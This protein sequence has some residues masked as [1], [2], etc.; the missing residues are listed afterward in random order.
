MV[1]RVS[2]QR[3]L[4]PM[5]V[6]RTLMAAAVVTA[7]ALAA[8]TPTSDPNPDPSAS[9]TPGMPAT[10]VVAPAGTPEIDGYTLVFAK[11]YSESEGPGAEI[12][13]DSAGAIGRNDDDGARGSETDTSDSDGA[14]T[15]SPTT[16]KSPDDDATDSSQPTESSSEKPSD[17]PTPDSAGMHEQ[18]RI[19]GAVLAGDYLL[20]YAN[21]EDGTSHQ[22]TA[23]D[24][25]DGDREWSRVDP[26]W[27]DC[28][29]GELVICTSSEYSGG[30]WTD[31]DAFV[32]DHSTGNL[33]SFDVGASGTFSYVGTSDQ[34][35]YFLTWDGTHAVHM[36]GFDST[37]V[38]VIDKNLRASIPAPTA[39]T[40]IDAWMAGGRAFISIPGSDPGIYVANANAFANY[41][42]ATPCIFA[43]DGM[44]CTDQS[45]ANSL[46]AVDSVGR[47]QWTH[48]LDGAEFLESGEFSGSL[49]QLE[50]QLLP[51]EGSASEPQSTPN[52]SGTAAQNTDPMVAR[53][54]VPAS[55][56]LET[57]DR[58]G[59]T[60]DLGARGTV[61]IG[62][63]EPQAI[64]LSH[65]HSIV[66]VAQ[67]GEPVG[68]ASTP[69]VVSTILM[70]GDG[71]VLS[72]LPDSRMGELSD[73]LLGGTEILAHSFQWQDGLL[74]FTDD[75]TGIVA[76]YRAAP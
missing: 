67:L 68:E 10:P 32:F 11:K 12:S 72:R 2:G 43:T 49:D 31:T 13:G 55:D 73:E 71:T 29:A 7:S 69:R 44:A 56:H 30:T 58:T 3:T 35:A 1:N 53:Y 52:P 8:C 18:G 76:V 6:Q 46:T 57:I 27:L 36:T 17:S 16:P 4:R 23:Y 48:S 60:L 26:G 70:G 24:V 54:L 41:A 59:A 9:E 39:V 42:L 51:A 28:S 34:V 61:N 21:D 50:E 22:V 5:A 75:T 45:A 74:V 47:E 14:G 25:L 19:D 38:P 66:T 62:D 33:Q 37:G 63:A 64:D 65:E 20:A 40:A 15:S